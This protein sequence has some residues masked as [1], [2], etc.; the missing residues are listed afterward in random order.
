MSDSNHSMLV[1]L[2]LVIHI[3]HCQGQQKTSSPVMV[4]EPFYY[5]IDMSAHQLPGYPQGRCKP[6]NE[7][8]RIEKE[9]S[10]LTMASYACNRHRGGEFEPPGPK[11]KSLNGLSA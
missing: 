9:K 3:T 6:M 4:P 5:I 10:V 7:K 8:K 11:A 2:Y 1:H